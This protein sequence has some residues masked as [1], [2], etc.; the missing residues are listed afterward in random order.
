[1]LIMSWHVDLVGVRRDQDTDEL[2]QGLGLTSND[3][4]LLHGPG[5]IQDG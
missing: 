4:D 2:L 3:L 5:T 1:M